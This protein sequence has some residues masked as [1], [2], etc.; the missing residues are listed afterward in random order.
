LAA[1]RKS[2]RDYTG[3]KAQELAEKHAKEIEAMQGRL[4]TV[5]VP[6]I[7]SE[8]VVEDNTPIEVGSDMVKMRVNTDLEDVTIGQGNNFTFYRNRIYT[9]PKWVYNHLDEKGLVWH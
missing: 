9:V 5:A 7:E 6:E 8:E 4:T 3:R 2:P 1:S